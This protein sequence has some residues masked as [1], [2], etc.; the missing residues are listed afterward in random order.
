MGKF[1][2]L[3]KR[4]RNEKL[5]L[6]TLAAVLKRKGH[7][8]RLIQTEIEDIDTYMVNFF[9]DFVGYSLMTGDHDYF[10]ELNRKLKK[11]HIFLS[12]FGGPHCT[13]FP[14]IMDEDGVDFV[15]QGAGEQIICRIVENKLPPGRYKGDLSSNIN[16]LPHPDR[17]I[18]YKYKQFR[19]N[20]IKNIMTMRDCPY[21]CSYCYNHLW[22]Q[23]YKDQKDK[24]F[25]RKTVENVIDEIQTIRTHYPVSKINFIDDNFIY[26]RS[27]INEFCRVYKEKIGLPF[28][29]SLRVNLLDEVL[30]STLHEAGLEMVNFAIESTNSMVQKQ[31]LNRGDFS[32]ESVGQSIAL[33]KQYGIRVRMQNMIGLPVPNPLEDAL[34][35]LKFNLEHQVEDSWVS[36][37]QPYPRTRLGVYCEEQG[38][39]SGKCLDNCADSFFSESRL[40]IPD[41]E[42]LYRL[43]KWWYLIV[44]YQL[45]EE[46]IDIMMDLPIEKNQADHLLDLRFDMSRKHFYGLEDE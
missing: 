26:K 25:Q 3:E 16:L 37:Y 19:D 41:K 36:I 32:N 9:P 43:Q 29:I 4:I 18:M 1:L 13:F 17:E 8:V 7:D 14:E 39:I 35:T 24:L 30:I 38:Y 23:F 46:L 27:W 21:N 31:V 15:V 10:L 42:K 5:G 34:S 6:M 40:N 20:P 12:V 44:R 28:L 11:E 2:F 45:P 33:F 22:K